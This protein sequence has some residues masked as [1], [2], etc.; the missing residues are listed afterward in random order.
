MVWTVAE[1]TQSYLSSSQNVYIHPSSVTHNRHTKHKEGESFQ[2]EREL[3]AFAEKMKNVS[4][5]GGQSNSGGG[6]G[7]TMLKTV[8]R[9]D[10]LTYLLFGATKAKL[11]NGGI[12]CDDWLPIRGDSDLLNSLELVKKMLDLCMLRVFQGIGSGGVVSDEE[13]ERERERKRR[14]RE[15][16][17]RKKKTG[18]GGGGRPGRDGP[19]TN[20]TSGGDE[21]KDEENEEEE[22]EEKELR[23]SQAEVDDFHHLTSGL[24]K[25]LDGYAH[26][27]S[28]YS[29][30]NSR[31]STRPATPT[32]VA[33]SGVTSIWSHSQSHGSNGG[34][35]RASPM[36]A[37]SVGFEGLSYSAKPSEANKFW[38]R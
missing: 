25:I 38:R 13:M 3:Y 31:S 15:R 29:Q 5:V 1:G 20:G 23:M 14:K 37:P 19:Q 32:T 18:G 16:E 34:S 36:T 11:A 4:M 21:G 22:E 12:M 28:R 24:V 27:S 30:S 8:T 7:Q 26:E 33:S 17:Q 35:G 6:G 9:L 10:P 2:G